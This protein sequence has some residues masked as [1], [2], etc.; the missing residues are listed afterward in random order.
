MEE[1]KPLVWGSPTLIAYPRMTFFSLIKETK[2]LKAEDGQVKLRTIKV[3]WRWRSST[4]ISMKAHVQVEHCSGIWLHTHGISEGDRK[5]SRWPYRANTPPG[6]PVVVRHYIVSTKV[7]YSCNNLLGTMGFIYLPDVWPSV[8]VHDVTS[9]HI[10]TGYVF[11]FPR[12]YV[13]TPFF[14]FSQ[15]VS[16]FRSSSVRT[17]PR[18]YIFCL[19]F[20]RAPFTKYT[21]EKCPRPCIPFYYDFI[22]QP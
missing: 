2:D 6:A 3:R 4:L 14:L 8:T 7:I 9:L 20:V 1:L 19:R 11:A 5:Y 21:L 17:R 10:M 16:F 13:S 18:S 22:H 15:L 12:I